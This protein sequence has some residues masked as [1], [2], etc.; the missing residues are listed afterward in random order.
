MGSEL[1]RVYRVQC[2][3]VGFSVTTR[4]G[5]SIRRLKGCHGIRGVIHDVT[6]PNY[7]FYAANVDQILNMLLYLFIGL[8]NDVFSSSAHIASDDTDIHA[9]MHKF[10]APDRLMFVSPHVA[11]WRLEF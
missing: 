1:Y 7:P 2:D 4:R 9:G 10:P 5:L 6:L 11:F 3:A 8:F